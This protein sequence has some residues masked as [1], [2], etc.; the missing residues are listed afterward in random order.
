MKLGRLCKIVST[1]RPGN[2]HFGKSAVVEGSAL[3]IF[4]MILQRRDDGMPPPSFRE[5]MEECGS[6]SPNA[7]QVLLHR[8][9]ALGLV[10]W[11]ERQA[12]TLTSD[13]YF[14]PAERL[15]DA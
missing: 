12:R 6:V 5:M 1:L 13:Y 10:T 15:H 2:G 9:H 8:L 14:I 3:K 7:T 4:G 11:H